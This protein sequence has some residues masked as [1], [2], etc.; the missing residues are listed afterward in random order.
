MTR[1]ISSEVPKLTFCVAT[2]ICVSSKLHVRGEQG[3]LAQCTA[4]PL[5][6]KSDARTQKQSHFMYQYIFQLYGQIKA[7][8]DQQLT[9]ASKLTL[10]CS[11]TAVFVKLGCTTLLPGELDTFKILPF[12]LNDTSSTMLPILCPSRLFP[13]EEVCLC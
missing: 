6:A 7:V 9:Q 1:T 3:V 11:L 5:C 4:L 10:S 13:L 12:C 2:S 8:F